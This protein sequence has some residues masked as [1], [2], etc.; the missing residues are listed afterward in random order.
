M[1]RPRLPRIPSIKYL[2][3]RSHLE[4]LPDLSNQELDL[5]YSDA[6]VEWSDL[7]DVLVELRHLPFQ[8]YQV[9]FGDDD[10]VA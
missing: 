5:G 2:D 1:D 9:A 7:D 4:V 3:V 10:S 6:S 8:I